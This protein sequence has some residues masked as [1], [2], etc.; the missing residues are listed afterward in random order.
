[1]KYNYFYG[2]HFKIKYMIFILLFFNYSCDSE[3]CLMKRHNF[4]LIALPKEEHSEKLSGLYK[5]DYNLILETDPL[6]ENDNYHM[7]FSVSFPINVNIELSPEIIYKFES[8][9]RFCIRD[10]IREKNGRQNNI[11]GKLSEYNSEIQILQNIWIKIEKVL[12]FK[13]M[14]LYERKNKF[15]LLTNLNEK[16]INQKKYIF[17]KKMSKSVE[18]QFFQIIRV[19][20]NNKLEGEDCKNEE[21]QSVL[22]IGT[23]F[24]VQ[25]IN[26]GDDSMLREGITYETFASDEAEVKSYRFENIEN[27]VCLNYIDQKYE[28]K[29]FSNS[30]NKLNIINLINKSNI[31]SDIGIE[32]K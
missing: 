3:N 30:N 24:T 10:L 13:E 27:L 26:S 16:D 7:M 28:Y 25:E 12:L 22:K 23:E 14:E 2:Q 19:N 5:Y 20:L 32:I 8:K 9:R 1:M 11:N 29:C 21:N 15:F 6:S 4:Y 31:K 17:M 18:N